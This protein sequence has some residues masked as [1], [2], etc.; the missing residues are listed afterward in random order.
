MA[1]FSLP[2]KVL[3]AIKQWAPFVGTALAVVPGGQIP[4]AAINIIASAIDVKPDEKPEI[5]IQRIGTKVLDVMDGKDP[6]MSPQM[7]ETKLASVDPD[8]FRIQMEE[9]VEVAKIDLQNTL[10]ARAMQITTSSRMPAAVTLILLLATIAYYAAAYFV[11]IPPE[12]TRL[13]DG[14]G[15]VLE[16]LTTAAVFFWVGSSIGSKRNADAVRAVA[17]NK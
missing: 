10:N 15:K 2:P 17:V 12:N 7:L 16:T 9:R 6:S 11:V 5:T 13:I 1:G 8:V 4:A 3:S 14:G